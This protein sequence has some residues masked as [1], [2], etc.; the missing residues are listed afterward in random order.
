MRPGA[1]PA[2]RPQ[3]AKT[4]IEEPRQEMKER[5]GVRRVL[6][7]TRTPKM[8]R[9]NAEETGKEERRQVKTM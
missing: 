8:I 4:L 7:S 3:R 6:A 1:V 2:T 5:K 9:E